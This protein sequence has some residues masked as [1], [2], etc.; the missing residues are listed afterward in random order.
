MNN[1]LENNIQNI[2]QENVKLLPLIPANIDDNNY[3]EGIESPNNILSQQKSNIT[4][5]PFI[6]DTQKEKEINILQKEINQII[7]DDYNK[8]LTSSISNQTLSEINK[9]ISISCIELMND[10]LNKPGDIYWIEYIQF[11][12]KKN[13]RYAYIGILLIIIAIYLLLIS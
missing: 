13:Q 5:N 4:T 8:N 12:L 10:M 1:Q 3:T 6:T 9:N 7:V 2:Q 11:V